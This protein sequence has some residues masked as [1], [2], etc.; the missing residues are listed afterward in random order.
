MT[1]FLVPFPNLDNFN[2]L[3]SFPC[4]LTPRPHLSKEVLERVLPKRISGSSSTS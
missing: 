2:R 1:G 4:W 3:N